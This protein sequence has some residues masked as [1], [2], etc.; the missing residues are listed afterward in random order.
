MAY[1]WRPDA[2]RRRLV[3]ASPISQKEV[4]MK[5]FITWTLLAVCLS[6][7]HATSIVAWVQPDRILLA[8]DSRATGE[9]ADEKLRDKTCKIVVMKDGAFAIDGLPF[10]RNP[11]DNSLVWDARDLGKEAYANH[12]G[13]VLDAANEWAD[14]GVTFWTSFLSKEQAFRENLKNHGFFVI[15]YDVAGFLHNPDRPGLVIARVGI[16]P[17]AAPPTWSQKVVSTPLPPRTEPYSSNDVTNELIA[18]QTKRA[19]AA[20]AA[21]RLQLPRIKESDRDRRIL[22]YMIQQTAEQDPTVDGTVNVLEIT[23]KEKPHWLQ[24]PTCP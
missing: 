7:A 12:H 23:A 18:G 15:D 16:N 11:G 4:A 22:E 19:K 3:D 2:K 14:R 1:T 9:I 21:W 6:P 8:A 24:H 17:A 10:V 5:S 13:N 20:L